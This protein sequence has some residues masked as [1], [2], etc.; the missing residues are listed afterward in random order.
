ML[1]LDIA[2]RRRVIVLRQS[3]YSVREIKKRLNE[4]NISISLQALFNLVKNT[5]KQVN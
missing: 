3:V 5:V 4:E 1:R 2:T